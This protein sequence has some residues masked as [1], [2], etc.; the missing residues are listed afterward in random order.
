MIFQMAASDSF[1]TN[2]GHRF[3]ASVEVTDSYWDALYFSRA[4]AKSSLVVTM[5]VLGV[6]A[7]AP[8]FDAEARG[9]VFSNSSGWSIIA[10]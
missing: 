9:G 7:P 10:P 3:D 5:E 6:E 4:V 1:C 8:A 2:A